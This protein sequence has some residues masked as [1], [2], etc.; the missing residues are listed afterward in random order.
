MRPRRWTSHQ[1]KLFQHIDME[2]LVP[3]NHI[4][5][6][7]DRVLDFSAIHEW[8]APL[9]SER[10]GRPAVDPELVMRII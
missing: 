9:Y 6:Q 5:R 7:I 1:P 10:T 8:V 4:L 2:S 3:H